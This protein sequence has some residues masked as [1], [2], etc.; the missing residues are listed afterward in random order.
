MSGPRIIISASGMLT[1]GRVI[2]HLK[3]RLPDKGNLIALVGYQAMGTRGRRLLD[4]ADSLRMHGANIPVRADVGTIGGL[5]AHAD[6]DE[7][8]RWIKGDGS[9]PKV[10]FVTHG[11]PEA[12]EALALRLGN[13]VDST[14]VVPQL[15]DSFDLDG[16]LKGDG[17]KV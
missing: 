7:L 5:S 16:F 1:G 10:I 15:E 13:E 8:V 3:R 6:C 17:E 12:S 14:I 4:G 9:H 2:H 11:D